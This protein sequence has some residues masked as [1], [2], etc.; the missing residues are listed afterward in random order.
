MSAAIPAGVGNILGQPVREQRDY[1]GP[2]LCG[3]VLG[4]GALCLDSGARRTTFGRTIPMAP[5]ICLSNALLVRRSQDLC[6][7]HDPTLLH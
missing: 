1:S 5:P 7:V 3:A 4:S 6:H 2:A